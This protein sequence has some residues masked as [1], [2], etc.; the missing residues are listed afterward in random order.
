MLPMAGDTG[1][2][3]QQ[4]PKSTK[5]PRVDG[6]KRDKTL[7]PTT[8]TCDILS[9]LHLTPEAE[10]LAISLATSAEDDFVAHD[11]S[12]APISPLTPADNEDEPAPARS[13][14]GPASSVA[15][16]GLTK[17]NT[18]GTIYLGSTLSAPDKDALIK[19]VCGVYRAHLLGSVRTT[20]ASPSTGEHE[21]FRDRR[22]PGDYRRLDTKSVPT[23]AQITDFYRSIFLRSQMEVDCI[24]ISLVYVE[25]LIKMTAGALSPEPAN[26]RSVLF[27]CMVLAS[28]VWDDLSMWNCDFSKI[29]PSGVTFSLSRTNELEVALL[30]ALEYRVK[31]GASEYAKYYFLLRG[32]LCRSGLADDDIASLRPLDAR[33]AAA[34]DATT[35]AG[36][37][38]EAGRSGGSSV[39]KPS[40]KERSKSYGCAV[41]DREGEAARTGF[42]RD[43]D[44]GGGR[45]APP[46]GSSPTSKRVS[47]EQIVRM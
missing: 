47:L 34:M 26:W 14:S 17:R 15:K 41:H 3:G 2:P 11:A 24:I 40:M 42:R 28:K 33:G 16:P 35:A 44:G 19:C 22:A 37:G 8:A 46:Q 10:G 18:C 9:C 5:D 1:A 36:G 21:I 27:S 7:T 31:V 20:G 4:L 39:K 13:L 32:M 30:G 45:A 38:G 29:G 12:S 43:A 23:L 25:R 6:T